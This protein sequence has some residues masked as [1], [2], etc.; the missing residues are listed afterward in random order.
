ME[1]KK[2]RKELQYY[3][4]GAAKRYKLSNRHKKELLNQVTQLAK[5]ILEENPELSKEEFYKLLG[6]PDILTLDFIDQIGPEKFQKSYRRSR[7]I[8]LVIII[9]AALLLV[10]AAGAIVYYRSFTEITVYEYYI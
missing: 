8:T 2:L 1:I 10:A 3:I 4:T 6:S 9:I 5:R 7:L